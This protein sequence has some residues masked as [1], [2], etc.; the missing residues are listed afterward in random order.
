MSIEFQTIAER[1]FWEKVFLT[2]SRG[3]MNTE[4]VAKEADRAVM[5]WRARNVELST[6]ENAEEEDW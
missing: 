6:L 5:E 1:E 4:E 3:T 2:N